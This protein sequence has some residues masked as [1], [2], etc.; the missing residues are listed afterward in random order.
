[1]REAAMANPVPA[2]IPPGPIRLTV[3]EYMEL[4]NDGKRYQILDG[5]LDATPAPIPRHQ[6]ISQRL[7]LL[8]VRI[9]EE[10]GHGTVYHAPIDVI[11]DK[12]NIVQPDIIFIR[13]ERLEIIGEKNIQGAPDLIV[14][15]LSPS[16]RRTD[17]LVK[18]RIYA[19]FGVVH[20]WVVDPDIDRIEFFR[21]EGESYK[22]VETVS[23]PGVARPA[24][25]APLEIPLANVFGK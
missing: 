12:H 10:K 1:M 24:E 23:A 19:R 6:K 13:S 18:S 9:L 11:L 2:S 15:V 7:E 16:T 21:L 20:Y 25:F 8:L 14:E 5:E 22:L 4:P 3:D 17:I